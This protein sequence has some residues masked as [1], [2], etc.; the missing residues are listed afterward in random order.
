MTTS[1]LIPGLAYHRAKFKRLRRAGHELRYTEYGWML[2]IG[3]R[4]VLGELVAAERRIA[5]RKTNRPAAGS[6]G[7]L[8]A[9]MAG[10]RSAVARA[11]GLA[12]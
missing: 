12:A 11:L 2:H 9:L 1:E 10:D 8:N 6:A 7:F 5:E 3:M 4:P